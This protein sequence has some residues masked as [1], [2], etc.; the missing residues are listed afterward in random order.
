MKLPVAPTIK[1][2]GNPFTSKKS[3]DDLDVDVSD[4]ISKGLPIA[5]AGNRI[6]DEILAVAGGEKTVSE[7]LGSTQ[8]AISV[9]GASF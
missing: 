3:A 2:T 8:S 1:I 4:I 7:I 6:F 9:I 5:E